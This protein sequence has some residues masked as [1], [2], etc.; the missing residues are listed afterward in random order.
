MRLSIKNSIL[1]ISCITGILA[2]AACQSPFIS[3]VGCVSRVGTAP[4]IHTQRCMIACYSHD[5]RHSLY[6]V[7][8]DIYVNGIVS[9]PGHYDSQDICRPTNTPRPKYIS[10]SVS[11]TALCGI[12]IKSCGNHC[13]AGGDA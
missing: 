7:G 10:N 12:M 8:N 6:P 11:F 3:P 2:L 5:A 9:V 4:I 13:W 1:L